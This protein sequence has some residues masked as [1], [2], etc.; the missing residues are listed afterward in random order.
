MKSAR[1]WIGLAWIAL[2]WAAWSQEI[3]R[4]PVQQII[5]AEPVI[6][7]LVEEPAQSISFAG[8]YLFWWIR[9]SNF[10]PLATTG[11]VA[12]LRPGALGM[13][14]TVLLY[15][16][17]E[18]EHEGRS[19]GRFTLTRWAGS[20]GWEA[21]Y[22]FLGSRSIGF[23]G[24]SGGDIVLARP[25]V[26]TMVGEDASIIAFPGTSRGFIDIAAS[27]SMQG[28]EASFLINGRAG[29][30]FRLDGLVGFRFLN[31]EED[32]RI[33]EVTNT[34]PTAP[35]LPSSQIRVTDQFEA[36]NNFYGA[37]L[38]VRAAGQFRRL[39]LKVTGKLGL[40]VTHEV[41]DIRGF[42]VIVPPV[43]ATTTSAA[44]L[45]ALASNSGRDTRGAFAV[46]PEVGV[47]L[48][49]QITENFRLF[50]GY[51]F[52]YWSR[53]VRPGDQV[54]RTLNPN[55]IPT[56]ATFGLAGGPARPARTG[57]ETDFWAQGISAGLEFRY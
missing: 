56:S 38:G 36:S 12:D 1:W 8:E 14:G 41:T 28:A 49:F 43:G 22:L 4:E 10:P 13:P 2:P 18:T 6:T 47:N 9:D 16:S 23:L 44:G 39:D 34:L 31:L 29:E 25:F 40:G 24:F 11:S 48:G 15:G 19:G 33:D 30:S 46:V 50:G 32:L 57:A 42:T 5:E 53:V 54:D 17:P 27:S 21:S 26:N 37:Q 45:L 3:P 35:R 51:T 55:L 7:E 52:L 20:T